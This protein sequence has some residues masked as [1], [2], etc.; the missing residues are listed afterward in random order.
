MARDVEE[1]PP[2]EVELVLE[3]LVEA[4]LGDPGLGDDPRDARLGVGLVGELLDRELH[5][6]LALVLRQVQEGRFGHV[7][8]QSYDC[9]VTRAS[10]E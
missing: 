1:E 3:V 9:P 6:A 8:D 7:T 10:R 4:P 5:D 2:V